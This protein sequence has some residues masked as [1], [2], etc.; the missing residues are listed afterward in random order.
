[1]YVSHH[2]SPVDILR[3]VLVSKQVGYMHS[4]VRRKHTLDE[5]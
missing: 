1:M 4:L 5:I 3:D 2:F